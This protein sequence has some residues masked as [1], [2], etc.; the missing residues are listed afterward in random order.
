MKGYKWLLLCCGMMMLCGCNI[1]AA[2]SREAT[3]NNMDPRVLLDDV[4]KRGARAI[5]SKLYTA[6]DTWNDV[7]R[8]VATGDETWLRV[9]VAL[10]PGTDAGSSEMLTL[11]VGEA[12]EFSPE[13]V[14]LITLP[15]FSLKYV[16]SGPDVDDIRF[17]SYELSMSAIKRRQNR[18]S[19]MTNPELSKLGKEC[20]HDL[21]EAKIGIA[22]FYGKR[23]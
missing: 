19:A 11:A 14:F 21:E 10:H 3:G 1:A 12:L 8:H 5:V 6:H 9:A 4:A 23:K 17:N 16:C 22:A 18:I 15:E 13:N 2:G 20:I 7:L